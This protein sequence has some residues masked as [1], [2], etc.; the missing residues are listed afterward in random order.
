MLTYAETTMPTPESVPRRR[1]GG[2]KWM[3]ACCVAAALLGF[4]VPIWNWDR[5]VG[6]DWDLFSGYSLVLRTYLLLYRGIP[7]HDPW[8][9]G[10]LDLLAN[11]QLRAFSPMVLVDLVFGPH[12]ADL[13]SLVLYAGD[14]E[15]IRAQRE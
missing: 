1:V 7:L 4:S 2:F 5:T 9:R 13:A 10:G 15:A 11:P 12:T 8:V 14:A 3:L 6:F